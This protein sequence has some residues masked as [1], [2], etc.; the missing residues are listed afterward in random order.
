MR[1]QFILLP[2]SMDNMVY[3]LFD[4][5]IFT[6]SWILRV[7]DENLDAWPGTTLEDFRFFFIQHT[8]SSVD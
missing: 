3:E 4:K 5:V 8:L 1:S 6:G 2:R 7:H